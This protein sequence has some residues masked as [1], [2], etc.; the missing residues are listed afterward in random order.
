MRGNLTYCSSGRQ[1]AEFPS[2]C[3]KSVI[4]C[5]RDHGGQ[6]CTSG[7]IV[8]L[9]ISCLLFYGVCFHWRK[10]VGTTAIEGE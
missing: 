3:G 9:Q 5:S 1:L 7:K 2:Q 8:P 4:D 6:K 10:V